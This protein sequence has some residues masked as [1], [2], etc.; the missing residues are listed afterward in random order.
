MGREI[1]LSQGKSAVVDESD[2]DFLTQW[3]WTATCSNDTFRKTLKWYA[4]R[5]VAVSRGVRRKQYMHRLLMNNPEGKVVDHIDG[6]GLN[7][8]RGNL[9]AITPYENVMNRVGGHGGFLANKESEEVE[10]N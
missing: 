8:Q 3:K 4:F 5:M 10:W 7:N 2:F 6:D 9:R 1:P